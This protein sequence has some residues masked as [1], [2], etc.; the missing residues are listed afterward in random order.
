MRTELCGTCGHRGATQGGGSPRG[1]GGGVEIRCA[2]LGAGVK[3]VFAFFLFMKGASSF[4]AS[5]RSG[6]GDV[7]LAQ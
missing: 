1:G 6:E 7:M 4:V 3:V 5:V 2:E